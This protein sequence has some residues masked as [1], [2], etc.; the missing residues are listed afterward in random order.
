MTARYALYFAPAERTDL[1][2]LGCAW[3][4]RDP[5]TGRGLA[6][7]AVDG[8]SADR[9]RALTASPRLYGLHATLKPPFQL[10]PGSTRE[11]LVDAAQALAARHAVFA[12]PV[13]EVGMLTGFLALRNSLES[14]R[15]HALADAC[16]VELDRFRAN[17]P[18]EELARRQA[19]GLT[20]R[21]E[22]LLSRFGYPY[23]L[24]QWRFHITLTEQ[25]T[26]AEAERLGTWLAGYFS[27]AAQPLRC[28][29]ICLF[30]QPVPGAE[31]Q[32]LQRF[33]LR[34]A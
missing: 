22:E 14:D 5:V 18:E 31:F 10:R 17:A 6:Q 15:L 19:A 12:L 4:G 20:R 33:S 32:I 25:L 21:Q 8:F 7:P 30:V 23:L 2:R 28:E 3:L 13:L 34:K 29:D 16:A 1:W 24:E 11:E 27:A 26:G 9:I